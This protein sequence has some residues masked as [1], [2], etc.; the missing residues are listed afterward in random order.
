MKKWIVSSAAIT[1]LLSISV[2]RDRLP[3]TAQSSPSAWVMGTPQSGVTDVYR[4]IPNNVVSYRIERADSTGGSVVV[5]M[6]GPAAKTNSSLSC[7]QTIEY[8][9]T[10]TFQGAS[11]RIARGQTM[12]ILQNITRLDTNG[13]VCQNVA[14]VY[15]QVHADRGAIVDLASQMGVY[16]DL[17]QVVSPRGENRFY[18]PSELSSPNNN[19]TNPVVI[20]VRA[21]ATDQN[22][23][24]DVMIAAGINLHV[25]YPYRAETGTTAPT[26][27]TAPSSSPSSSPTSAPPSGGT[28]G[29]ATPNEPFHG[30]PNGVVWISTGGRTATATDV[31]SVIRSSAPNC[32]VQSLFILQG[33][34]WAYYLPAFRIG[35]INSIPGIAS[36]FV[37]MDCPR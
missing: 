3:V 23:Y 7:S 6:T 30:G 34:I 28:L 20:Q 32:T 14:G 16:T 22:G 2:F 9:F 25:V 10:W 13:A 11:S 18:I 29:T 31:I 8:R 35:T 12:S 21:N 33:G 24:V 19:G 15:M 17:L 36:L 26:A 37:V 1:L 4:Y 27:T 5:Q